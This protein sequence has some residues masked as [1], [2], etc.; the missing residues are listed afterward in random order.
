MKKDLTGLEDIKVLVDAFYLKIQADALLGPVFALRIASDQWPKHL[1]RMYD[2]WNTVLFHQQGYKGN[3]FAKH[4]GLPVEQVHFDQWVHLFKETMDTHFSGEKAA[5]AKDRV[6]KM[7][8]L[9]AAKLQYL[10]DYPNYR[11][12]V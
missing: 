4:V 11:N 8:V 9:F 12:I 10:K 6:E 1:R 2:F 7:G 3:P 5:E